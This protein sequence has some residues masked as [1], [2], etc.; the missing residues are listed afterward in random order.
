M[1]AEGQRLVLCAEVP[2][3]QSRHRVTPGP[4][5]GDAYGG[6]A[7][8]SPGLTPLFPCPRTGGKGP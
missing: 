6:T 7:E 5:A 2:G 4:G 1:D 8:G 3:T